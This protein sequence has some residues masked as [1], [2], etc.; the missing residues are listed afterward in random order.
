MS[1]SIPEL[2][3]AIYREKLERARRM[4]PAER[5]LAGPRLFDLA[6]EW[7][8]AGIRAQYPDADADAVE[9]IFR[10]RLALARRLENAA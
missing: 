1:E 5:L 3:E 4:T 9:R 2:A 8:K 7:V 6:S 10:A